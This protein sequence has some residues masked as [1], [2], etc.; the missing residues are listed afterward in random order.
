MDS[1]DR[2]YEYSENADIYIFAE[3]ITVAPALTAKD[4][5]GGFLIAWDP[6]QA[7]SPK[8]ELL[9]L[10]HEVSHIATDAFY[11]L[12]SDL[13]IKQQ[14]EVRALRWCIRFLV[15]PEELQ[16]AMESGYTERWELA[17]YFEV[18]EDFIAQAIEYY[19]LCG[20]ICG[21]PC[22]PDCGGDPQ[23]DAY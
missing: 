23:P 11:K 16:I 13:T 8:E 7:K 14:Q 3:R 4:T 2:L 1:L 22:K 10:I 19:M 5:D 6:A 20:A 17:E 9:F 15:D 12:N 18:P 21:S